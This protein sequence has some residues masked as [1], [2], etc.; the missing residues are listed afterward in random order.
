MH[1]PRLRALR[2][3]LDALQQRNNAL[4]AQL[5]QRQS[6]EQSLYRFV[7]DTMDMGC[8]II[9][10]FDGPAGPLSDYRHVLTNAA[11]FTHAGI[12]PL[13]RTIRQLAPRQADFWVEFYGQVLRSGEPKQLEQTLDATGRILAITCFRIEPTDSHQVAVLFKDITKQ[14]HADA[15]LQQL[16]QQ[17]ELSSSAALAERRLFAELVDHSIANVH[18]I[19]CSLRWMAINHQARLDFHHLYGQMPRIGHYMPESMAANLDDRDLIMPLWQRALAGERLTVVEAFGR[20]A[21]KRYF[22]LRFNALRDAAGVIQGAYLFAYDV[23]ERVL[24]QQRLLEAETALRQAQK[25]EAVGQLSGGI[26]HD[27]NNLL[28]AV[29]G[30]LELVQQRIDQGRFTELENLL[31]TANGSAQR[32]SSL[33]HRLLAFSRKQTLLPQAT[34]VD[35]LVADLT[36][37]MNQSIGHT[38]ELRSR[39]ADDLWLTF[40]DPPQLESGLLN[41][42]INARDALPSGGSIEISGENYT[43]SSELAQRLDLPAGDYVRVAITDNGTGMT[44]QV[45]QRA[46]EPFYTTKP[47]GHGT[48]LGLSMVYGFV[49]QS[50]GQVIIHS[51]LG[52]GTCVQLYLPRHQIPIPASG[53]DI[54]QLQR[55]AAVQPGRLVMVVE[56]QPAMRTVISEVLEEL[57]H[58]VRLFDTGTAALAALQNGLQSDLLITDIGLPGGLD[59][60]KLAA[61]YHQLTPHTPVLFITGYDPQRLPGNSLPRDSQIL[62]KP[63]DLKTLAQRVSQLLAASAPSQAGPE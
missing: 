56:D 37:L 55:V 46:F 5:A 52:K 8:C 38:I 6:S 59:G 33:V 63:F 13:G 30:A 18:V 29:L 44:R 41:L 53:Q 51:D 27:F 22:E 3:Q 16:N 48:G 40:V 26:A 58:S 62:L 21:G 57:G 23:S 17:L 10:F 36:D 47:Q 34:R 49:R 35:Q 50:G 60:Y 24:N 4:E 39:F 7:F 20:G 31:E 19:D 61:A 43:C 54:A 45:I 32:A 2:Q 12:D 11:C 28:G 9:E 1:D 15:A 42:C 25:M 14:R